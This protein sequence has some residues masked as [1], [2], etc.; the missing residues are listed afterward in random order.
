MKAAFIAAMDDD[1]NTADAL[2]AIFE[3]VRKANTYLNEQHVTLQGLSLW[4]DAILELLDVLGVQGAADTVKA[5]GL[6]EA[7]IEALI[8]ER[9]R[10]RKN[11]DFARADEIRN[12][13]AKQNIILEDTP[14]GT[15]WYRA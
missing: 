11:R 14:Q 12:E 13:L 9:S 8:E 3:G 10:A 15:R 1:F 4:K 7:A 2:A 6:D 5:D